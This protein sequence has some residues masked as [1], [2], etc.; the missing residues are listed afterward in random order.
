VFSSHPDKDEIYR[1][2]KACSNP[3][4]KRVFLV[5]GDEP[6]LI[7]MQETLA[8]EGISNVEIPDLGDEFLI[9]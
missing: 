4:L 9:Q 5:H 8:N 1:Y 6:N 2:I 3:N 7:A